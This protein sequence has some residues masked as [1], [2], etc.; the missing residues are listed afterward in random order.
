MRDELASLEWPLG[1][2]L[3]HGD[4]W[5]GNLLWAG[6]TPG[7]DDVVFGDWDRVAHGPREVDLIPTWHAARRYGK[8]PHWTAQFI[9]QYGHDLAHWPGLPTLLAMRDLVQASGPLRRAPHSAP[10]AR[11]LRQRVDSLRTGDTSTWKAL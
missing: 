2:S 1:H 4:A 6:S 3:I 5:A 10:H 11:A 9:D 7:P 8:G